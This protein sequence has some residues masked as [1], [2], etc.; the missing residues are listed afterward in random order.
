[1]LLV[2]I[3]KV[4]LIAISVRS[5][6]GLCDPPPE[7]G[8][9][10]CCKDQG[11]LYRVD[12]NF[13]TFWKI[14]AQMNPF[15]AS[16]DL[17]NIPICPETFSA[18]ILEF[19]PTI[20]IP[21]H[22]QKVDVSILIPYFGGW[23]Y[24]YHCVESIVR[25]SGSYL[26]YE[27]ILIDDGSPPQENAKWDLDNVIHGAKFLRNSENAGF[28]ASM[29]KAL[30]VASG[31]YIALVNNDIL[32]KD[33]WLS[34]LRRTFTEH[35]N[36][37]LVGSKIVTADGRLSEACAIVYSDGTPEHLSDARTDHPQYNYVRDAVYC[38]AASVLV[39]TSAFRQLGGFDERYLPAYF[40]DTDLCFGLRSIGLRI[41]YQ[42]TSVVIHKMSSTY[43]ADTE[44]ALQ[45]VRLM[46]TNK[47]KFIIKWKD[48]LRKLYPSGTSHSV[49]KTWPGLRSFKRVLVLEAS[50][51]SPDKDSGSV[52]LLQ[53]L[54]IFLELG[55]HVTYVVEDFTSEPLWHSKLT[56]MGV[57]VF[58]SPY[59]MSFTDIIALKLSYDIFFIARPGVATLYL[60]A[61][62]SDCPEAF[63]AY[64]TVD[65][66][67]K[68][69]ERMKKL[70]GGAYVQSKPKH[71]VDVKEMKKVELAH[72]RAA[73]ITVVVSLTEEKILKEEV[74]D[75]AFAIV[76]N[77]HQVW[78]DGRY[79]N[80]E[81]CFDK[82]T[83]TPV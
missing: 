30:A 50:F 81:S 25:T 76:S 15:I 64:D 37:G 26:N 4:F 39:Q 69:E 32:V 13:N 38:S 46:Q 77:I 8:L 1:M 21:A 54:T 62:R 12:L 6:V 2:E 59:V 82:T 16:K 47:K 36:V 22:A 60:N 34:S 52:R 3:S 41:L 75:A 74:P 53:I 33:G 57:E 68:R 10:R 61:I 56:Q 7:N 66:H 17:E 19:P 45:K 44:K 79:C 27:L 49:A 9:W 42:P 29:N 78:C 63:V 23:E 80:V 28:L 83:R 35:S 20:Y 51:I 40:E 71:T 24:T 14:A 70:R 73:N 5:L 58:Y 72:V 31:E 65:L 67:Y 18:N 55:C 48:D 43:A 11:S